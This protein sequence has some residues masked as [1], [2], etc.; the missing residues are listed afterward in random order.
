MRKGG[1]GKSPV[2]SPVLQELLQAGE[3]PPTPHIQQLHLSPSHKLS[4][5][6]GWTHHSLSV[7]LSTSH[8]QVQIPVKCDSPKEEGWAGAGCVPSLRWACP[9]PTTSGQGGPDRLLGCPAHA[10]LQSRDSPM[11]TGPLDPPTRRCF[12]NER[13]FSLVLPHS[14]F[15]TWPVCPPR[16]GLVVRIWTMSGREGDTSRQRSTP[17]VFDQSQ[18]STGQ[19]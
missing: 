4:T 18:R 12:R 1:S 16:A 17:V 15:Q 5:W 19:K 14:S 8:I 13:R 9:E 6:N 11:H 3:Q 2:L 7:L 10:G